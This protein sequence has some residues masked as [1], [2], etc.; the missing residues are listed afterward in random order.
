MRDLWAST[1]GQDLHLWAK[2]T[3][4]SPSIP[5][6]NCFL[7]DLIVINTEACFIS[8]QFQS[9]GCDT[10]L[11]DCSKSQFWH[12]FALC[13]TRR[14]LSINVGPLFF[15]SFLLQTE[16]VH[17]QEMA[18]QRSSC[19]LSIWP[20]VAVWSRRGRHLFF[21]YVFGVFPSLNAAPLFQRLQ[22]NITLVKD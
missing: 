10:T 18:S 19:L 21:V 6:K 9:F 11:Q 2:V 3:L 14:L 22:T 1:T 20:S 7:L 13:G 16:W 4:T 5:Q 12:L 17:M 15:F 8:F